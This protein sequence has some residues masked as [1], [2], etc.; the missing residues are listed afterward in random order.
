MPGRIAAARVRDLSCRDPGAGAGRHR[1][2][3]SSLGALAPFAAVPLAAGELPVTAR[4]GLYPAPLAIAACFGAADRRWP[5]RSGRS[6]RPRRCRR[7]ASSAPASSQC[8]GRPPLLCIA[9][10]GGAGAGAR[11]AGRRDRRPTGASQPGRCSARSRRSV[12]FRLAALALVVARAPRR[13]AAP[14]ALRLALANLYRPGAPH[15]GRGRLARPRPRRA[16]GDR[17]GRGQYRRRD[18]PAT[19]RSARRR[20]SS[21]TFSPIRSRPST[22]CCSRMPGVTEEGRVPS[23]RGRIARINGVPV[24]QAQVAPRRAGPCAASA[25]SP[26]RRPLPAGS[27]VVAGQLVA[28][29]LS[30]AAARLLRRRSRARHG[31]EARRH[32]HRQRARARAHRARSPICAR[33]TGPRSA[34][35]SRSCCRRARSTAR[36]ETDIATARTAPGTRDGARARRHRPLPQ[37]LGDRGQGRAREPRRR[38]SRRSPPRSRR[39]RRSRS[40]RA[41]WCSPAPSPPASAA[42]STRRWCSRCWAR[43][44]RDVT[45]AFLIEYGLLGLA[46]SALAAAIGTL[47]AWLLLTRVMDAPWRF[48]GGRSRRRSSA[49]HVLHARRRLCRHVARLGRQGRAVSPERIGAG[50]SIEIFTYCRARA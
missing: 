15:V 7:R 31:L 45:R 50:S 5:S 6:A 4:L 34:S 21:S 47:A 1:R 32:A 19:C 8:S 46:A 2:S 29:G 3:A 20:S 37:R 13:P 27:R 26:T 9:R 49:C 23:L 22:R 18:R 41:R 36:R 44:A 40:P 14:A 33:S 42:A 38:S 43:R 24:E 30:R 16:G 12:I 39:W 11:R 35:I 28:R 17:A 10:G 25:A 48:P